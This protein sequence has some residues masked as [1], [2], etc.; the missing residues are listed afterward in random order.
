MEMLT[1]PVVNKSSNC[2]L[3]LL[4]SFRLTGLKHP[5]LKNKPQICLYIEENC[6]SL[7][8]QLQILKTWK[9]Q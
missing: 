8:D 3:E 1:E 7:M 6:C 2:D 4:N 9:D 5:L